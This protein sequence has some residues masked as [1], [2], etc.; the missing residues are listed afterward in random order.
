MS[1]HED[2]LRKRRELDQNIREIERVILKTKDPVLMKIEMKDGSAVQLSVR[3][4]GRSC[5]DH[6]LQSLLSDL[7][8]ELA[9]IEDRIS[10][11]E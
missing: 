10:K 2:V 11:W 1:M 8:K 6:M 7:K 5:L 3:T 4:F 9:K